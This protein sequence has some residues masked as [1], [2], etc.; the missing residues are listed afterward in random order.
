MDPLDLMNVIEAQE[1]R[2]LINHNDKLLE[3]FDEIIKK[4]NKK[5]NNEEEF[6]KED[7]IMLSDDSSDED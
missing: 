1:I 4:V 6:N 2:S 3:F 5:I 7:F